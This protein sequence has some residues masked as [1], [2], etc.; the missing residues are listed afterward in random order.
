MQLSELLSPV[1]DSGWLVL[2]VATDMRALSL[3]EAFFGHLPTTSLD[4]S[5]RKS[6][7]CSTDC[8]IVIKEGTDTNFSFLAFAGIWRREK[9]LVGQ[10]RLGKYLHN[11]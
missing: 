8:R 11:L 7:R 9:K 1:V 5:W 6:I 2:R 3:N 10:L 4:L